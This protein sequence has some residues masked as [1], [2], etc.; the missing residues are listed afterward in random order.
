MCYQAEE[1][2]NTIKSI[3]KYRQLQS[4]TLTLNE[5]IQVE[6]VE[7]HQFIV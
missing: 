1:K 6:H 4:T 3:K 5:V 7:I 2:E